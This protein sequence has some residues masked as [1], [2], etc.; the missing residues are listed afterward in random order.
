MYKHVRKIMAMK[1]APSPIHS[2]CTVQ[3]GLDQLCDL[4]QHSFLEDVSEGRLH[5][6]ADKPLQIR[7]VVWD[8]LRGDGVRV[9]DGERG[10]KGGGGGR[11][12]GERER[13]RE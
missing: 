9:E 5:T 13:G 1:N 11:E 12:E 4:Q 3:T 7:G 6:V 8:E 10:R 2:T